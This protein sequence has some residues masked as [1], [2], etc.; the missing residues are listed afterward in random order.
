MI[1][2]DLALNLSIAQYYYN[3][4]T[5]ANW[6]ISNFKCLDGVTYDTLKG[7]GFAYGV[8]IDNLKYWLSKK[9]SMLIL[10]DIRENSIGYIQYEEELPFYVEDRIY[11]LRIP[12]SMDYLE[13]LR[14]LQEEYNPMIP[15]NTFS[16]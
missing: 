1:T 10:L 3:L 16:L 5:N 15:N 13:N 2:V 7:Y 14:Y 9:P 11:E 4:N 8:R 12:T 6:L